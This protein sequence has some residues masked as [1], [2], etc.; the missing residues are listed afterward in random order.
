M[1]NVES[2]SQLSL[3]RQVGLTGLLFTAVSGFVGSGWLFASMY[4]AQLAGPA[5]IISW[6]IGSAVILVLALVYAE[7][8]GML[9][10]GGALA[11]VPYFAIGPTGGFFAGWMIWIAYVATGPIEV[12]AVLDYASNYLPWL[13]SNPDGERVLTPA[14]LAL[15]ATL[16]VL[17]TV[18]NLLGIKWLAEVSTW[19]GIWKLSIPLIAPIALII[20]G[21]KPENFSEFGGFAPYGVA[22]VLG[23]VSSGGIM[24]SYL[25]FRMVLDLAGEVKNP[26]VNVPLT[27]MLAVLFS[28]VMY[29][30]LQVAFIGVIPAEHL[31]NGWGGITETAPG[32]PFA[33]FAAILGLKVLAFALYSDAIISPAGCGLAFVGS[34][35]RVN[36][37]MAKNRQFPTVFTKL[38]RFHV[39]S[40]ALLVNAAIGM[41]LLL[42]L[43]GWNEMASLISTAAVMSFAMGPVSLIVMRHQLPGFERPFRLPASHLIS[44][45]AFVLVGFIVYWTGWET[46]S[47]ILLAGLFGFVFLAVMRWSQKQSRPPMF[48]RASMWMWPYYAGI[49]VI[50]YLGNYGNGLAV[51]PQGLDLAL[52]ALLSLGTLWV[53]VRYRLSSDEVRTLMEEDKGTAAELNLDRT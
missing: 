13:T 43:P 32:G 3:K 20:V 16:L 23:A 26:Q 19:M 48:W 38:N 9:P 27:L 24:F 25:G 6:C 40:I 33:A 51:L 12:I 37:G 15:A 42:P 49:A 10:V 1:S 39:P 46:N 18:I 14:G 45:L 21:L 41:F 47:K 34:T 8:G 30:L 53:A 11:R 22:G 29:V 44:T 5:S 31:Q 35:A 7:L 36:Y 17:F 2:A 28:S 52:I 4:A 50:S